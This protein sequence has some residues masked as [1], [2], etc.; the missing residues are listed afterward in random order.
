MEDEENGFFIS[1]N[2][3]IPSKKSLIDDLP[4]DTNTKCIHCSSPFI[5]NELH[6]TFAIMCCSQ[7]RYKKLKFVTKTTAI[8]EYLLSDYDLKNLKYISRPNPH[9]GN[10]HDMLLYLEDEIINI[11]MNKYGNEDALEKI[12]LKRTE[13]IKNRKIKK[14]KIKI[15]DLK[16][17]TFVKTTENKKHTHSFIGTDK[18]KT[19]EIC[20]LT[21]EQEEI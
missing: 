19:C 2:T 15:R 6:K 8:K 21:L 14:L 9:K 3:L 16:R 18:L 12:K 7:C 17:C 5:D 10:W 11:S 1:E 4:Y 13:T 20:G